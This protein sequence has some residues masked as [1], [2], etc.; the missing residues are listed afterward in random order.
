MSVISI[1]IF[2]S[3]GIGPSWN[4]RWR[5]WASNRLREAMRCISQRAALRVS[6]TGG[7]FGRIGSTLPKS[8]KMSTAT[9]PGVEFDGNLRIEQLRHN[10]GGNLRSDDYPVSVA[11]DEYLRAHI[12]QFGFDKP[13]IAN[14][15]I[16]N[17]RG[18]R[19]SGVGTSF[20]N[21]FGE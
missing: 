4:V 1:G 14:H 11:V 17:S 6:F 5:V 8:P 16:Q 10:S 15:G 21:E 12:P 7:Q 3:F 2:Q 13:L 9:S 18:L 20:R 19:P